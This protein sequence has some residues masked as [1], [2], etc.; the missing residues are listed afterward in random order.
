MPLQTLDPPFDAAVIGASGGIG[1]AFCARLAADPGIRRLWMLS[2][3]QPEKAAENAVWLPLDLTDE[4]SIETAAAKLEAGAVNLRLALVA[5][6]LLHDGEALQPEKSWRSMTADSLHRNFA[7]NAIGPALV[8]KHLLPLMPRDGKA[9]F[10]AISAR[11]GS[12]SDN[13]AGG[14]YGYRASK[15][16]LNMIVKSL[17]IEWARRAPDGVCIGLH[18]GTVASNLSAPFRKGTPPEKLFEPA[19][20]AERLL[21]VI[22]ERTATDTGRCYAWDGSAIEP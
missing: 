9:V 10:A 19:Y 6:G 5:S 22:D 4:A 12:V 18:P 1:N 14:W 15:A 13:R 16:A 7:V 11:V 21:H 2:R 17:A 8:A 3:S 20:A